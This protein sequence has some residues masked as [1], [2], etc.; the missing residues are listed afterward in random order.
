MDE[1]LVKI[2]GAK[3]PSGIPYIEKVEK[4]EKIQ[5]GSGRRK[6]APSSKPRRGRT[7]SRNRYA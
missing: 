4:S 2:T 7:R 3:E 5:Q 1:K 6:S